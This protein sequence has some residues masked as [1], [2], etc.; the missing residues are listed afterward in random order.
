MVRSFTD[1]LFTETVT[2]TYQNKV[3]LFCSIYR[4]VFKDIRVA[5]DNIIYKTLNNL[6]K[7]YNIIS[8]ES[9]IINIKNQNQFYIVSSLAANNILQFTISYS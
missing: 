5:D 3:T 1:L 9:T 2:L 8:M 7:T 6:C 4:L